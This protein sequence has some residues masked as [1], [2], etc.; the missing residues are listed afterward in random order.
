MTDTK[1]RTMFKYSI[2]TVVKYNV[3]GGGLFKSKQPVYGH[4]TGFSRT[5]YDDD[6]FETILLVRWD[7]GEENPIHPLNV[8][9]K[10]EV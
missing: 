10:E 8:L 4:V 6:R 5:K 7:T 1:G 9:T 2:G 3:P